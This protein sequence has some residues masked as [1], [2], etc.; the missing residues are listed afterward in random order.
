MAADPVLGG[1]D[2]LVLDRHLFRRAHRKNSDENHP[3][4][5]R[6]DLIAPVRAT[7]FLNPQDGSLHRVRRPGLPGFSGVASYA[8]R[9]A[10]LDVGLERVGH[11]RGICR[12]QSG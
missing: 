11:D 10:T 1:V 12:R 4:R 5:L 3:C 6:T 9:P 2:R 8:A 7:P